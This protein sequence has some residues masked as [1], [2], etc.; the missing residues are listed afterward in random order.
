M[1]QVA[2]QRIAIHLTERPALSLRLYSFGDYR[3]IQV[4]RQ[5]HDGL[6][7]RTR[8]RPRIDFSYERLID[9][10]DINRK[11]VQVGQ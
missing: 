3:Q 5:C 2:L 10:Q 9:L 11:T 6:Y 4:M 8:A 7:Q 1:Q